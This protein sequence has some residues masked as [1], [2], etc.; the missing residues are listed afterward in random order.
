[1]ASWRI[2]LVG[3]LR[4][5]KDGRPHKLRTR[6]Q[7]LLLARLAAFAPEPISRAGT[8]L[9][10]WPE[11]SREQGLAYLRRALMEL[12]KAGINIH[13]DRLHV[14]LPSGAAEC[15]LHEDLSRAAR[16]VMEGIDHPIADEVRSLYRE[17]TSESDSDELDSQS[18]IPAGPDSM[19]LWLG[20]TLVADHPEAALEVFS[21]HGR[22][23]LLRHP[24]G[25]I[26]DCMMRVLAASNTASI[27]RLQVL[28]HATLAA[29]LLTRYGLANRLANEAVV[30]SEE[31]GDHALRAAVLARAAF[32]K[33]E[34][35]RWG[36][37]RT[38]I[39]S[40]VRASEMADDAALPPDFYINIAG[41]QWHLL[42]LDEAVSNYRKC[43]AISPPGFARLTAQANCTC[44]WS[45]Y[46]ADVPED[47]L[48]EPDLDYEVGY[49]EVL[50]AFGNFSISYG[51]RETDNA[52]AAVIRLMQ[53]ALNQNMERIFCI[54]LDCAAMVLVRKRLLPEASAVMRVA[55]RV[56]RL[57][58]N[59]RSPGERYMIRRNIPRPY[60]GCTVAAMEKRIMTDEFGEI[61]DG[62]RELLLQD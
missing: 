19:F 58:G 37:T 27:H 36:E 15:D 6:H 24:P 53:A 45:A 10:L 29:N 23:L 35:R 44:L 33:M 14:S 56:R 12:R 32:T 55:T 17:M 41:I 1:M 43:I 47:C 31:I 42:Q 57:V 52:T 28:H 26:L 18:P 4:V 40:A 61:R 22:S 16:S 49:S 48:I 34:Q 46:G 38:L 51:R 59:P 25:L 5:V 7:A 11:A 62:V 50:K 39:D 60:S 54:G 3:P 21:Q 2:E 9:L 13:T 8:A 20:H 30:A